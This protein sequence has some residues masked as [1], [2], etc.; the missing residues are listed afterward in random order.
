MSVNK[1][2][3]HDWSSFLR[4]MNSGE[5]RMGFLVANHGLVIQVSGLRLT[6]GSLRGLATGRSNM[7]RQVHSILFG[8]SCSR[9]HFVD[10]IFII[11]VHGIRLLLTDPPLRR[12]KAHWVPT[13]QSW[14]HEWEICNARSRTYPNS[15]SWFSVG[16]FYC[17]H[18]NRSMPF[19]YTYLEGILRTRYSD[20]PIHIEVR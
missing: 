14:C 18:R 7:I 9:A 16:G 3:H 8:C 12:A 5:I 10:I 4:H 17:D 6:P 2:I 1:T 11:D 15:I 19:W 13:N 20:A